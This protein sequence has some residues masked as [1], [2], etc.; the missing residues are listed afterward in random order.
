M[1]TSEY[2]KNFARKNVILLLVVA[3]FLAFLAHR[4]TKN[5]A[6]KDKDAEAMAEFEKAFSEESGVDENNERPEFG[7][8]SRPTAQRST[9]HP[10]VDP[11]EV[12]LRLKEKKEDWRRAFKKA[13][14][15]ANSPTYADRVNGLDAL[16]S[17]YMETDAQSRNEL[18]AV[19]DEL[20][21]NP[22]SHKWLIEYAEKNY[23]GVSE[24]AY[25]LSLQ[26]WCLW[27]AYRALGD[28]E[29]AR[30]H[31]K[32]TLDE[33]RQIPNGNAFD[34][35]GMQ[36]V[37]EFL[38][39]KMHDTAVEVLSSVDLAIDTSPSNHNWL[40]PIVSSRHALL[41][42]FESAE[43]V[44][45]RT[46]SSNNEQVYIN[47][48]GRT[49]Q[50]DLLEPLLARIRTNWSRR[51]AWNRA[52]RFSE[53]ATYFAIAG[54]EE[55]YLSAVRSANAHIGKSESS[56]FS[57]S[58]LHW[59]AIADAFRGELK[60]AEQRM[61]RL[62]PETPQR[63]QLN[64]ALAY[65]HADHGNLNDAKRLYLSSPIYLQGHITTGFE[66]GKLIAREESP[67]KGLLFAE[68]N[69]FDP[70]AKLAIICG[71]AAGLRDDLPESDTKLIPW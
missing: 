65:F 1:E 19:L 66:I 16:A 33:F 17:M 2:L 12:A 71:I 8:P 60:K 44:L 21:L 4:L 61:A 42:D 51:W 63:S 25:H 23:L 59:L 15:K 35:V 39:L 38:R 3:I 70:N 13:E 47:Y 64:N 27:H 11:K 28:Y 68:Q 58:H 62:P 53:A 52:F 45:K 49:E 20:L 29:N 32:K 36:L 34:N 56:R 30:G 6:F 55:E 69:N 7:N 41:G 40:L 5:L 37:D 26:H 54:M 24:N 9:G 46:K 31:L 10:P 67:S 22:D 50:F 43:E 57:P 14:S 48:Y 18:F